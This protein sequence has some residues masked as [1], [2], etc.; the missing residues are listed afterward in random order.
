[1]ID[2][3]LHLPLPVVEKIVRAGLIYF[4][5]VAALRLTGKRALA[6]LSPLDF[7]VLLAVANAVQNGIIGD[8][9]SVTGGIIG[10]VTLFALNYVLGVSTFRSRTV[11]HALIGT[12]T[13]LVVDGL[14]REDAMARE[15]MTLEDLR[16]AIERTGA[17][18]LEEVDRCTILPSG[19][20][21]VTVKTP[22]ERAVADEINAKLDRLIAKQP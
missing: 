12:P 22:P 4:F 6:Q 21:I 19:N 1:M 13:D 15:R 20:F 8:E 14:P 16:V 9:N 2:S 11:R 3:I 5:L 17:A 10:A 7:V 18:G